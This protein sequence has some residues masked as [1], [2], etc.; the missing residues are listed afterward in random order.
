MRRMLPAD[1]NKL[2]E[3]SNTLQG[4][5]NAANAICRSAYQTNKDADLATRIQTMNV[6]T[7][8]IGRRSPT[9]AVRLQ[10]SEGQNSSHHS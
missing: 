8:K 3:D 5:V 9:I 1:V 6:R 4:S 7:N 10:D 2:T